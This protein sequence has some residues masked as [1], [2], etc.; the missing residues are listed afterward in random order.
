MV[1]TLESVQRKKRRSG[2]KECRTGVN[3]LIDYFASWT[4]IFAVCLNFAVISSRKRPQ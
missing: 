4:T 3:C 2:L 1:F